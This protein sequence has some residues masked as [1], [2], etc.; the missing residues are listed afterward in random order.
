MDKIKR[1]KELIQIINKHNYN[2]YVLDNPT[3]ADREYDKIY[4]ELVSLERDTGVVLPDSPTLKVGDVVLEGFK[5]HTHISRLYSLDKCNTFEELK[6]WIDGINKQYGEQEFTLEYK[7]DGL[8]MT[9]IYENGKLLKAATRGNGFVGEE[10]T[11]QV[12]TIKS[13]PL[14]I[15]FKGK[16]VVQ[17]E[18]MIRLSV[19]EEY[20]KTALEPL[21][22]ARNA[23]AGAIR[24]LDPR[25]TGSRNLDMFFYGVPYIEGKTFST[26][27]ELMQFLVDNGFPVYNYSKLLNNFDDIKTEIQKIDIE[28]KNLDILIDGTVLKLNNIELRNDIGYTS[29]F[30][31]W[32]VAFKF[33][34]QELTT[35]LIDVVWQVGRT[36]KIT[37][38]GLVE[39]IELAGATVKRATLNNYGDIQRKKVQINANVFVRRSNEV[40]PEILG[41]ASF[42][43]SC[44]PI[45]KPTNCPSC[46][47]NLVEDG[48]NLFC[49]NYYGCP[50]QIEDRRTHYCSR[51]AM[52]IE[53][54][55]EKTVAVLRTNLN[56]HTVADL[57]K[58]TVADLLNLE[59]FKDKKSLNLI[60][61][62]EKSKNPN[63]SNFI[64]ALGINGVGEKTAKDLAKHFGTIENL[65]SATVEDLIVVNDIGEVIAN[66]IY[67]F[68]RDEKQLNLINQLFNIGLIINYPVQ[69]LKTNQAFTNKIIVLTGDLKNYKRS[70]LTTILEGFGAKVTSSVSSKTDLVIVGENAGSKFN[71]AQS[72]GIKIMYEDELINCLK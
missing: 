64:Y 35:K 43:D 28:K 58:I 36:G 26:Q 52:N 59:S 70:E 42:N 65:I 53:G 47:A 68:F 62:I 7:F 12:L 25:V 22:N 6:S 3:I 1:I 57:Y 69:T 41:V 19:L 17:G 37:P 14:F 34:A 31:K 39:P 44:Y 46:G 33:E 13:I 8:Q 56:V 63:F 54:I 38:I 72:L 16:L 23:A 15:N 18:A 50:E 45:L 20:N 30:P 21:K 55:S 29:K 66:N 40:I 67:E 9:V 32:A 49:P 61:S 48:A 5:K 71:K 2:Y 10:V 51:N 11:N 60:N 4:D 27:T 24:N